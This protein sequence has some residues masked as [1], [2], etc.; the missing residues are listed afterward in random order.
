M[1]C[2][3]LRY[4]YISHQIKPSLLPNLF[5]PTCNTFII[6]FLPLAFELKLLNCCTSAA[7]YRYVILSH[8]PGHSSILDT[9]ARHLQIRW[10]GFK[11]IFALV[12]NIGFMQSKHVYTVVCVEGRVANT[13]DSFYKRMLDERKK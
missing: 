3:V 6:M 7:K 10:S 1:P 4:L 11:F 13:K 5:G 8:S 9:R 12:N 2:S